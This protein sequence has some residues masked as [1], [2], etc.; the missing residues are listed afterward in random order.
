MFSGAASPLS[1]VIMEVE[2]RAVIGSGTGGRAVIGSGTGGRAA[3]P[4]DQPAASALW[5]GCITS[6]TPTPSPTA[7][8]P[9]RRRG[10]PRSRIKDS[11]AVRV[12]SASPPG[13]GVAGVALPGQSGPGPRESV[14]AGSS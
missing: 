3:G 5:W 10:V 4:A 2:S 13:A 11:L 6:S 8:R 12:V 1:A 14:S 9:A 7:H